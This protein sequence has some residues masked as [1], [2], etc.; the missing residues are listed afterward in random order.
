MF[1]TPRLVAIAMALLT[2]N[3]PS[4]KLEVVGVVVQAN[5]ASLGTQEAAEG[6]TIYDGD[7]LSTD[8]EGTLRVM[9]GEAMV[10][11]RKQ[12]SATVRE[13]SGS[14]GREF[15]V[16]LESGAATLSVTA[17]NAGEIVACGAHIR[18]VSQVRGVVRVQVVGPRELLVYAQRGAAVVAYRGEA[19]TI[20]EG[21]AYRVLLNDADDAG[22]QGSVAKRPVHAARSLILVA[23]VV[24]AGVSVPLVWKGLES[25]DRP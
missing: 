24:A 4:G 16:E 6:T 8:A 5:H 15:A 19:E 10:D 25:P 2:V 1:G 21:K 13:A 23:I 18:P 12:S 9:I 3:S 11:L 22:P 20:P 14:A 7:R 17:A